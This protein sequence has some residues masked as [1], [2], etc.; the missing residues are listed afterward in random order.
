MT[1][2]SW[3]G[4]PGDGW[5][6]RRAGAPSSTRSATKAGPASPCASGFEPRRIAAPIAGH[7][8]RGYTR[9][10]RPR[11]V[12]V[13]CVILLAAASTG[14]AQTGV[15]PSLDPGAGAGGDSQ[16]EAPQGEA[17]AV[18]QAKVGNALRWLGT[19]GKYPPESAWRTIL[20]GFN[21]DE[22]MAVQTRVVEFKGKEE[23]QVPAGVWADA[24]KREGGKPQQSVD[25][26]APEPT[27][28]PKLTGTPGSM[29]SP[30]P[31]AGPP[32]GGPAGDLPGSGGDTPGGG[33]DHHGGSSPG[34]SGAPGGLSGDGESAGPPPG[35]GGD[36]GGKLKALDG[37][38]QGLG[39][40]LDDLFGPAREEEDLPEDAARPARGAPP[41]RPLRPPIP[42]PA[43]S[44]GAGKTLV[45]GAPRF[46]GAVAPSF[47]GET[48]GPRGE[49]AAP[50][51]SAPSGGAGS[52]GFGFFRRALSGAGAP[53]G[54]P[55]APSGGPESLLKNKPEPSAPKAGLSEQDLKDLEELKSLL[56]QAQGGEG[57]AGVVEKL[58]SLARKGGK[59]G[60]ALGELRRRIRSVFD[61]KDRKPTREE[62]REILALAAELGLSR[63]QTKRLV[64]AIRRSVPAFPKAAAPEEL[65]LWE[66][67]WRWLL[68]LIRRV[69]AAAGF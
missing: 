27:S 66:R 45:S 46:P 30:A 6:S 28:G 36:T 68:A 10:V 34:G 61:R 59:A 65:S 17:P 25:N 26:P 21:F 12:L 60:A 52:S 51:E 9:G 55:A 38:L 7:R 56:D 11:P 1:W 43:E 15:A 20:D 19:F 39:Q 69:L 41:P 50:G 24:G 53:A 5:E 14:Y 13:L 57:A 54:A 40:E 31:G 33:G 63:E 3:E 58:D 32:P 44:G 47:R 42:R 48:G 16:G 4:S 18:D 23:W 67:F 22:L 8:G 64:E 62:A 37:K 35:T 2:R 29:A 49:A